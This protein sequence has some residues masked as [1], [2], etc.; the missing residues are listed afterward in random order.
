MPKGVPAAGFR[1][2]KKYKARTLQELE[3]D[4]QSKAPFVWDE[5]EKYVKP[6]R[7]PHCGNEI[8]V[9][10]KE[11]AM[12]MLDRALGKPK[13]KAKLDITQT[14]ELSADQAMSIIMRNPLL[15]R[16]YEL[17]QNLA[18]PASQKDSFTKCDIVEGGIIEANHD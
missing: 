15:A 12:Y 9:V 8:Q 16:A 14:I 17:S 10:D 6:F 13:Q 5:L 2:T 7:C 3:S 4:I 18:L 1:R 11:V